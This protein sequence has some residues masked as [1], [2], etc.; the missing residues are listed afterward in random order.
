MRPNKIRES[1]Y[2]HNKNENIRQV[3]KKACAYTKLSRVALP[4]N[5]ERTE[6][7]KPDS[8]ECLLSFFI[9]LI[10]MQLLFWHWTLM[11]RNTF[12]Y[13]LQQVHLETC[14]FE[15]ISCTNGNCQ[16]II[17]R[18]ALEQHLRNACEWRIMECEYCKQL[19]PKKYL[20]VK[21]IIIQK[22]HRKSFYPASHIICRKPACLSL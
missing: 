21:T 13:Y 22:K 11:K 5:I 7:F 3:K 14:T 15:L 19:H 10:V 12:F 4:W 16:M 20:Q 1:C 17:E 8:T 6:K 9:V 18:K 2:R